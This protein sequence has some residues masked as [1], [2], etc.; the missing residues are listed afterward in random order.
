M[1]ARSPRPQFGDKVVW[2]N[3][4]YPVVTR[5]INRKIRE[6]PKSGTSTFT[7]VSHRKPPELQF[8]T[9]EN[10]TSTDGLGYRMPFNDRNDGWIVLEILDLERQFAVW[11]YALDSRGA[12]IGGKVWGMTIPPSGNDPA[13][14]DPKAYIKLIYQRISPQSGGSPASFLTFLGNWERTHSEVDWKTLVDEQTRYDYSY[15]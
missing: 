8:L 11:I 15:Q 10:Y 2:S 14:V 9:S 12:L 3:I 5:S 6:T 7:V 13:A 4:V 1:T